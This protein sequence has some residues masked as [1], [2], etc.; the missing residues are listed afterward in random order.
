MGLEQAVDR[1]FRHEVAPFV[2]EPHRQLARAQLGL[3]QRQFDNLILDLA[4]HAVPHP[5]WRRRPIGEPLRATITVSVIPAVEGPAWNAELVQRALGWQMRSEEH[6]SELQSLMRT[7][8]AVFCWKKKKTTKTI[9][10]Q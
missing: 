10:V 2:G 5:A 3:F 9:T 1:S 7:S 8:Y 6:T 4:G